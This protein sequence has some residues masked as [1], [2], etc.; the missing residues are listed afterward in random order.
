MSKTIDEYVRLR[1]TLGLKAFAHEHASPVLWGIGILGELSEDGERGEAQTFL[2]SIHGKT[3]ERAIHRRIW[4]IRQEPDGPRLKYIRLGRSAQN[5]VVL[6]DYAISHVHC[7]FDRTEAGRVVIFDLDSHNGTW[8]GD[9]RLAPYEERPLEVEEEV[10]LGR[11]QFEFLDSR[12]FL[13]RVE[14]LYVLTF[15]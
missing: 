12:T 10:V 11:Y 4:P 9:Y 2:A 1:K 8:V 3:E 15:T 6:P 7:G 14:N 13:E 5:D